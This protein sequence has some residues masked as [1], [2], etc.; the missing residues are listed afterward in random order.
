[1]L[2]KEYDDMGSDVNSSK[3]SSSA[4]VVAL[5]ASVRAFKRE[6]AEFFRVNDYAEVNTWVED[7]VDS[8]PLTKRQ[9]EILHFI[10]KATI[11]YRLLWARVT[12]KEFRDGLSDPETGETIVPGIV[13]NKN[14]LIVD[15]RNLC[16]SGILTRRQDA[17]DGSMHYRLPPF[18]TNVFGEQE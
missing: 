2:F 17:H 14:N 13:S 16:D 12:L 7:V 6:A 9:R 10:R 11:R 8:L 3:S 4:E 1:M 5:P 15:I 18:I